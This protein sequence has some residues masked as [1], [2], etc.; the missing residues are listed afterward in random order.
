M[1]KTL[2]A[3]TLTNEPVSIRKVLVAVDL[4]EHSEAT[5]NYAAQI[6]KCFGASLVV[7][8]VYSPEMLYEYGGEGIYPLLEE[9]QNVL[10]GQLEGFAKKLQNA[11][12]KCESVFRVGEPA[13]QILELAREIDV[14]LI[15][16]ASHHPDFLSRLFKLDR[17]PRIMH[18]APCPVL[19]YHEKNG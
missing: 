13:E 5:G 2:D 14:D 9:Q 11:V 8:H 16:T 4:S 6:A 10:K 3:E 17:A 18:R 12:S 7:V 1:M 15:V 19:V